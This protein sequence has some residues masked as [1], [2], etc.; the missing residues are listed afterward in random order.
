MKLQSKHLTRIS[1]FSPNSKNVALLILCVFGVAAG[2]IVIAR[3]AIL[4]VV[5]GDGSFS[6]GRSSFGPHD[7]VIGE[8]EMRLQADSANESPADDKTIVTNVTCHG[9]IL[10]PLGKFYGG[11]LTL[12]W[13]AWGD[14]GTIGG[15]MAISY[16]FGTPPVVVGQHESVSGRALVRG[17]P[18]GN[19]YYYLY[20]QY[21][22][23]APS[24]TQQTLAITIRTNQQVEE[25]YGESQVA[26]APPLAVASK[27]AGNNQRTDLSGDTYLNGAKILTENSPPP[28]TIG[29]T[30]LYLQ[31]R[32]GTGAA[33]GSEGLFA[34]GNNSSATGAGSA[35]VGSYS[36]AFGENSVA[37]S[38]GQS[39]GMDASAFSRGYAGGFRSVAFSDG[40]SM[41][42]YSTTISGG[43]AYGN[44]GV[45]IGLRAQA[46]AY[47]SVA[48]GLGA[49]A[50]GS[51]NEWRGLD[52]AFAVGNGDFD[53]GYMT[54]SNAITTLKNGQT[55]LTNR[56]WKADPNVIPTVENSS[57][58]ALVVEGNSVLNGNALLHGKVTLS[59]PQGDIS[60]GIYE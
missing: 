24:P 17:F 1:P 8:K 46:D 44:Y 55:T 47:G 48:L 20:L 16:M 31:R 38:R 33:L 35:A 36:G 25:E 37:M 4:G 32:I 45:G 27:T 7:G 11:V 60:M 51:S 3:N 29:W 21:K 10:V 12:N 41:G 40:F 49:Y 19:G 18:I 54:G 5:N 30:N 28:S 34:I 9:D 53:Q 58:N 57:A 43:I 13:N 23:N 22:H 42:D 15:Q 2:D 50:L 6:T 26:S 56:A 59:Q 14:H 39:A 52:A